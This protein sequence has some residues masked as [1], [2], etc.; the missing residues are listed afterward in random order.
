MHECGTTTEITKV[1]MSIQS[2][3][4]V[5]ACKM[6]PFLRADI[7]IPFFAIG[8]REGQSSCPGA[9]AFISWLPEAS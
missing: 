8:T 7:Y 1:S 3:N 6:L 9:C 5:C 4:A 2:K